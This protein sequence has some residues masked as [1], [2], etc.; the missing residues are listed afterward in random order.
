MAAQDICRLCDKVITS[1]ASVI[2]TK[3][4]DNILKISAELQDGVDKKLLQEH[5]PIPAHISCKTNYTRPSNVTK[6]KNMA[7]GGD[8]N[9]GDRES[10]VI[11][12]SHVPTFNIKTHCIYC[13]K[14]MDTDQHNKLAI[15]RREYIHKAETTELLSSI[16]AKAL[17]R[18][19]T[20]GKEVHIRVQNVGDLVAAEAK[21]HHHCQVQFHKTRAFE[22][23]LK[24]RPSGSVDDLKQRA[25]EKLCEDID[26]SDIHQYSII[27]LEKLMQKFSA[28]RECYTAKHLK[29]KLQEHY[30]DSLIITSEH[31][32]ETIY[33]FLDEA[34]RILRDSY[35]ATGLTAENIVDMAGT[36]I[37]DQMRSMRYDTSHYP[38][39]S[40]LKSSDNMVSPLLLRL[41]SHLIKGNKCERRVLSLSHGITAAARPR[42]FVSPILL[43]IA[44]YINTNLESRELVDMLSNISFADDYREV[45]RLYDALLPTTEKEYDWEGSLLNFAL[46]NADIDI[47]TLTGHNTPYRQLTGVGNAMMTCSSQSTQTD[48]LHL[49]LYY[50]WCHVG[51]KPVAG[52]SVHAA[53]LV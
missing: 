44:V 32:K 51:V 35:K 12:R 21:Y 16:I 5:P 30:G 31:G 9:D 29:T 38:K 7:M 14:Y 4:L 53:K 36:L 26:S 23:K 15:N 17:E 46:D 39:F 11:C 43:A 52:N 48:H 1:E 37:E 19:D 20:W 6:R 24:G 33:T 3:G 27:D 50:A 2:T 49:I 42:S 47:R 13:G 45:L 22:K 28:N 18:D 10:K 40:D 41:L 25:F 34:S 8:D